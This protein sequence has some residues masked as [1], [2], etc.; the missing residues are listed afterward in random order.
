MSMLYEEFIKDISLRN[1]INITKTLSNL[2]SNPESFVEFREN[3]SKYNG[4][5]SMQKFVWNRE[6]DKHLRRL[7]ANPDGDQLKALCIDSP[8]IRIVDTIKQS[9]KLVNIVVH[10]DIPITFEERT[11]KKINKHIY[12]D[13]KKVIE[14]PENSDF[15]TH[16]FNLLKLLLEDRYCG[17]LANAKIKVPNNNFPNGIATPF[18]IFNKCTIQL[19]TEK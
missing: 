5:H 12:T 1:S 7:T 8:T 13:E 15:E 14:I 19:S 3:I 18:D 17:I 6:L 4:N 2:F 11:F 10:T 16:K 9:Y